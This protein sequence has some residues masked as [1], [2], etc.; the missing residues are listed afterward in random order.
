[1]EKKLY[2][3]TMG[4]LYHDIGKLV[5]RAGSERLSHSE[6]GA[7]FLDDERIRLPHKQEIIEIV[8]YHHM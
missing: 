5:Q 8:R 1:M 6:I 2:T 3:I 7:R 4:A